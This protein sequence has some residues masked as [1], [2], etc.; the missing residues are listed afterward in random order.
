M[1]AP[2][3]NVTTPALL[4]IPDISGFTQFV[5]ATE[6]AHSRHIIEELLEKLIEANDIG[7]QVSEVEGDA[8]LFYRFGPPPPAE[9][10][11]QQVQKMFVTFHSHL[12]LYDTQRICQCGA[13]VTA[14]NL[15]LKIVAHYGHITQSHIKEHV[16]LFG[17]DVITVHRLLKNDISHHEYA[18]FTQDLVSEWP[19]AI[20]PA[21]AQREEGAQD[22]DVGRI[23]Y[24]Y[25]PLGP[26]RQLVPEPRVE[27]FSIPGVTVHVFSCEQV[28]HAPLRL[29]FEVAS[30]L[31]MRL[32]W[33]QGAKDVEMLNHQ[34]NCLGTKHR[35]VVDRN[36]PVMVTSGSTR[37]DDTITLTETDDKKTMCSV[38]TL[39]RESESQ[40]RVRIDGFVKNN[41]VLRMLF[42][43]LLKK[44]LTNWFQ[45]SSE[46]LKHL[47]QEI[48]NTHRP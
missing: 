2:T 34:F 33:M 21:W 24:G 27:D 28:V 6:I 32:Q 37:A 16:K 7:L 25:V 30:D 18:L 31:P 40:T 12:R 23:T 48:Y 4:F 35:C 8:I 39:Q 15:T 42:T 20:T 36:S 9:E 22:Y 11:C 5:Q 41:W 14:Q 10:F 38:Y 45:T 46:N 17:Q 19:E 47:C 44:K 26:L 13:C 43:L 29:V 3:A 1:S